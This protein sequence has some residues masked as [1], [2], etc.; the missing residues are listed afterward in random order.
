MRTRRSCSSA[1]LRRQIAERVGPEQEGDYDG[2]ALPGGDLI[3][4]FTRQ[5]F[6]PGNMMEE[7]LFARYDHLAALVRNGQVELNIAPTLFK[8]LHKLLQ[9]IP[10]HRSPR[11]HN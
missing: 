7:P 4:E 8:L 11:P 9:R 3:V 10:T 2:R 5:A 6:E 1:R